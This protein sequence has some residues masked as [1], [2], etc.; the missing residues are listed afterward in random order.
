M[1]SYNYEND[2]LK[3]NFVRNVAVIMKLHFKR[4][5]AKVFLRVTNYNAEREV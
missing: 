3:I 5:Y 4:F 2:N 1:F